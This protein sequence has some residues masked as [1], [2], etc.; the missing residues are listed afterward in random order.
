M[1]RYGYVLLASA[2]A[3]IAIRLAQDIFHFEL[4]V[5][6]LVGLFLWACFARN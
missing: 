6:F 4:R 3:V 2:V 5:L 1:K